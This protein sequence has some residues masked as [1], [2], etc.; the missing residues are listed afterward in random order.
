MPQGKSI[1]LVNFFIL[2]NLTVF[3]F[4]LHKDI[5]RL[6]ISV[7]NLCRI[8][9]SKHIPSSSRVK[10]VVTFHC[11]LCLLALLFVRRNPG[12]QALPL[13][14]SFR[15]H[16]VVRGSQFSPGCP[17]LLWLHLDQ[18]PQGLLGHMSCMSTFRFVR[19]CKME[20]AAKDRENLS[21]R[22]S[23]QERK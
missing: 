16:H 20:Q 11:R 5:A 14:L 6:H 7:L 12:S 8:P 3:F 4:R 22:V 15:Q 1:T 13:L 10:P 18:V 23:N 9:F 21:S 17:S 19:H 2:R